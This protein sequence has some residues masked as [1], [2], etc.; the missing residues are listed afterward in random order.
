M[1]PGRILYSEGIYVG[2]RNYDKKSIDPLFPFGFG[3]SYTTFEYSDVSATSVSDDGKFSVSFTIKNTGTVDG[4]EAAQVYISD[5]VSTL[6]RPVRELKG[7]TKVA[8]KAGES[9]K[10]TVEFDRDALGYFNERLS[11]WVAEEG[12]FV[13][14]V[15]ASSRDIKLKTEIQLQKTFTWIGL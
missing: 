11:K 6:P 5:P 10:A 9:K 8:L 13:V 3:L 1:S 4:R 15:A 7:F 2:Y 14:E 12:T